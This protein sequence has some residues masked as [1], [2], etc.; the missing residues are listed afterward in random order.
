M[1]KNM[2]NENT[3][4]KDI[5]VITEE[6]IKSSTNFIYDSLVTN[7]ENSKLPEEIFKDYF[8]PFFIGQKT[9]NKNIISDWVSIAGTPMCEVDIIDPAGKTLFTVPPLYD[10]NIVES[11]NKNNKSL[12][13]V[14][15]S[16][17]L[18]NSH[19]PAVAQKYLD[20][21]L[22]NKIDQIRNNDETISKSTEAW[23]NI[24]KR[25]DIIKDNNENN[26]SKE[27]IN[28]DIEY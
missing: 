28:D 1:D 20:N 2:N 10:T 12:T 13:E 22:S 27:I 11:I 15:N 14:Y 7:K 21:E 26:S 18:K 25:Y 8:L 3:L 5:K 19:L 16:Y 24:L 23:N 17:E 9:D 6:E 4:E